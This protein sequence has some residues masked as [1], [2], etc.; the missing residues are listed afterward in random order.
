MKIRRTIGKLLGLLAIAF[1]LAILQPPL[2]SAFEPVL[3]IRAKDGTAVI[4][5]PFQ[6]LAGAMDPENSV[7]IG[8]ELR[9][10]LWAGYDSRHGLAMVLDF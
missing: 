8:V 2:A 9:S 1:C 5:D 10:G 4:G 6:K 3:D 7:R